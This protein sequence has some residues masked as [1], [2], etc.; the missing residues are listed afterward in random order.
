[1]SNW[2]GFTLLDSKTE[3]AVFACLSLRPAMWIIRLGAYVYRFRYYPP[4]EWHHLT[5]SEFVRDGQLLNQNELDLFEVFAFAVHLQNF[6]EP[7]ATTYYSSAER[8]DLTRT[9][10]HFPR[11]VH[12]EFVRTVLLQQWESEQDAA[13]A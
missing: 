1:M 8:V 11:V 9:L 12:C 10:A 5:A 13:A 3:H 6:I 7:H 2:Y 4:E